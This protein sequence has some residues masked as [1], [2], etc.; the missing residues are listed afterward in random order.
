MRRVF[1]LLAII[2]GCGILEPDDTCACTPELFTRPILGAVH[3]PMD[4]PIGGAAVITESAGDATGTGTTT[5]TCAQPGPTLV[6]NETQSNASGAYSAIWQWHGA[7]ACGRIWAQIQ[8][9]GQ[10]RTSDTLVFR[11]D[12]SSSMFPVDVILKLREPTSP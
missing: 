11:L 7:P 1:W 3:D 2:A 12:L 8:R 4:A 10:L 9:N 5:P 6:R